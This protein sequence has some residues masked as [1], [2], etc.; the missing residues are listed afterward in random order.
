MAQGGGAAEEILR[1]EDLHVSFPVR[2]SGVGRRAVLHAVRGVSLTVR[3]GETFGLV[4]ESGCGKTTLVRTILGL[5]KANS[6]RVLL[7][8]TELTRMGRRQLREWR[9]KMQVVFQ[10]P[11]SSLDPRM[12]VHDIIAEPLRI[13]GRYSAAR[14]DELLEYVGMTPEVKKR[15]PAEFSG[16]QRQRIGIARALALDPELLILDE[17]VS[18][19]DVSIQA[20]VINLLRQL[21]ARLGLTCLLIAHDLSVVHY[22]SHRIAAMYLGQIVETGPASEIFANPQHPYTQSL[23]AAAPVPRPEGR[24]LR[25]RPLLGDLPDPTQPPSGCPFRTRCPRAQERC[26]Q[27]DPPLMAQPPDGHPAACWFPGPPE[28]APAS[29]MTAAAGSNARAHGAASGAEYGP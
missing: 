28:T 9:P 29:R 22:M 8:G 26:A 20:Q 21:Q 6:G 25:R 11:Y 12:T 10:D 18:S 15:L 3:R 14:I 4:G 23:L 17:P 7:S 5:Q 19:L 16:G 27:E 13:N 2:R 24:E 1:V